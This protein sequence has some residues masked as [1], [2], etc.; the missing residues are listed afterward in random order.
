TACAQ[1]AEWRRDGQR[2]LRMAVNVSAREVQ[3]PGF[4]ELV[5][6]T[7]HEFGLDPNALER[8][9]TES[10]A[11]LDVEKSAQVRVELTN[12]GVRLAIDDFGSGYSSLMRLKQMLISVLKIDRYFIKDITHNTSD[13]AIV[14]AVMGMAQSMG[15]TVVAEGVE[16]Y[17]QLAVLRNIQAPLTAMRCDRIQGYLVSRPLTPSDAGALLAQPPHSAFG[18]TGS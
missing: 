10:M 11:T 4:T 15:L 5:M 12:R 16:T 2:G 14:R 9:L 6:D 17:E 3:A 18:L 7:L 1:L 8:E 13:A